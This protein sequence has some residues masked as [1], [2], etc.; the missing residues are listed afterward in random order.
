[1][2][3]AAAALGV[4]ASVGGGMAAGAIGGAA[5]AAGN[6]VNSALNSAVDLIGGRIPAMFI[7]IEPLPAIGVVPFDF[8][9]DSIDMS[10]SGSIRVERNLGNRSDPPGATGAIITKAEPPQINLKEIVFEGLTTKLRCDQLLRWIGPYGGLQIPGLSSVNAVN[11]PVI[12]F[13]WGLPA[14]GFMYQVRMTKC[15][16]SYVR[17]NQMGMPTRAKVSLTLL[18]EPSPLGSL[19]TNPT[20]GGL[21]GRRSHTVADGD[22]LQSLATAYY[23]RPS[24]WRAIAAVNGITNPSRVRSGTRIYLPN[25]EELPSGGTR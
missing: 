11:L 1:M 4:G 18:Q 19:P 8:N 21:P 2:T 3:L 16:I 10:R 24:A 6:V 25:A 14:V 7:C 9:P 23:G 17:F 5:N 22:T 20:S 15:N 13:S 12:T